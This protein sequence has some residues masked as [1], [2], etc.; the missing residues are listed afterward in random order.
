MPS[1]TI[2]SQTTTHTIQLAV[3]DAP[4][5]KVEYVHYTVTGLRI[6]YTDGKLANLV[7]IGTA[8]DTGESEE[9]TTR[10]DAYDMVQPWI[11]AEVDAHRPSQRHDVR[12]RV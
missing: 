9:L 12:S 5:L 11:R 7:V 10:L 6:T 1:I 3:A 2:S 4:P 8:E